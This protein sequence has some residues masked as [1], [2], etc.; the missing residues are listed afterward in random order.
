MTTKHETKGDWLQSWNP[1]D[2]EQW[3]KKLA[4]NTLTVTTVTLTLCFVAWFLPSAIIPKLNALGF[5]FTQEQ[6]YWMAA[7]PGISAGLL[8]L[9]WMMLPPMIG[10]RKMVSLTTLLLLLPV[11]GWGFEVTNPDV[12]YWRLMALA[13]LAGIGGG[14][15]SG[16]MPST[17][18]FFPKRMQGTALGIQ[19]GVG[20][21]GVSLVQLLTPWLIS[22]GMFTFLG[23]QTMSFAGK[24]D[25]VVWYQNS[26]L[27]YVPLIIVTAIWAYVVLKSVP[28]KASIRQQFDIFSNKDTW[29]MTLLYIMTF[30]TF[31]G[32]SAQFG[33]LM[34]NLY[35]QNNDNIVTGSGATAQLLIEG[36]EVPDVV[37][38]VFLGPLVGAAARIAF[39]PLTD[40][41]GGAIWTLI[42]GIGLVISIIVTIPSLTPDYSSAETLSSG[43]NLFLFGMLAIFL[44][45]GIG[46]ASTFKQMPMIF[47]PRQAGGVIGWTA[48]IAAF[49]PFL[50]GVGL[51]IMSPT[52]F[53]WIGVAWALMCIAITWLRY[54]RPGAPKP[55]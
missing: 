30:G 31:S 36:Y 46:N 6:L 26:A 39:S 18:Y 3:D 50:F 15:F 28:V 12:P 32:L 21:F 10:T 9:V 42:S 55:S 1:E 35:G 34:A 52:M 16:F 29:F 13:F 54:A 44:F 53:Y 23:S 45:S 14:A 22:F 17:S 8:R 47:E 24:S 43:F 2:P 25:V 40:R 4:W 41:M 11:L 27:V 49:G 37:K 5:T 19:A 7:M 20:N 48:A 38:F 51:T 33:L